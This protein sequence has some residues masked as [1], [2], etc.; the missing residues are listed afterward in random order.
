MTW[1]SS[2]EIISYSKARSLGLKKYF[3]GKPCKVGH[4]AE[5]TSSNATCVECSAIFKASYRNN[6]KEKI[7]IKASDYSK[8]NRDAINKTRRSY[9]KRPDNVEARRESRDL[10]VE[11][12]SNRIRMAAF[13]L[14]DPK[15]Q[16]IKVNQWA[17][18]RK[19]KDPVK[20]KA[21][22]F[23][24]ASIR[25]MV[26]LCGIKKTSRTSEMLGYGHDEFS[27]HIESLFKE[28]MNWNNYGEWHVD[29]IKPMSLFIKE[30]EFDPKVINSLSNLQPLW[31]IDNII[32]GDK[33]E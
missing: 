13:R 31:A 11:R 2:M 27:K 21:K 17:K 5:R 8:S 10:S 29:H 1:E 22:A 24:Y 32:K 12:E 15:L 26:K 33:Y 9:R 20:Y 23:M 4:V 28:G 19:E 18:S 25:R 6:N 30:G 3:T 7:S 16:R 14:K